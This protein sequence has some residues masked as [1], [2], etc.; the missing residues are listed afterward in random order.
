MEA[1]R[2]EKPENENWIAIHCICGKTYFS[3]CGLRSVTHPWGTFDPSHPNWNPVAANK[4]RYHKC[5][6][7]K[8]VWDLN[9]NLPKFVNA[10][11]QKKQDKRRALFNAAINK[12]FGQ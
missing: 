1:E 6:D 2:E 5:P 4:Y 11:E 7:C 12:S 10:E 3:F 8:H 9:P